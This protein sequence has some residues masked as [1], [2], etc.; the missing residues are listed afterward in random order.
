M[1]W[2]QKHKSREERAHR[3]HDTTRDQVV[4]ETTEGVALTEGSPRIPWNVATAESNRSY[5]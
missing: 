4:L 3:Q 2:L 5:R 1:G